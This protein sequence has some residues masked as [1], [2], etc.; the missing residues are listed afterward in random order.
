MTNH[1]DP[2]LAAGNEARYRRVCELLTRY[3]NIEE[4]EKTEIASFLRRGPIIDI[5]RLTGADE[6]A[7]QLAS[8]RANERRRLG[9]QVRDY[10]IVGV[11]LIIVAVL[12]LLM[13]DAGSGR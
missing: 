10:L 5:G 13:W 9:L 6:L 11:A 1:E 7:P 8:F 12:C 4:E 2:P 3:P